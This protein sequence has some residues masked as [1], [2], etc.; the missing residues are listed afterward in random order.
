MIQ[1]IKPP[2][3]RCRPARAMTAGTGTHCPVSGW[4][5]PNGELQDSQVFFEGCLMPSFEGAPA[6]WVLGPDLGRR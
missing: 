4:W 1:D 3:M 6:V 2:T 5:S